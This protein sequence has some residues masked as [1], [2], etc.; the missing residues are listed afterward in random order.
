MA[1]K[2]KQS[3]IKQKYINNLKNYKE[4]YEERKDFL[5]GWALPGPRISKDNNEESN[6]SGESSNVDNGGTN[7]PIITAGDWV[8]EYKRYLS[9]KEALQNAQKVAYHFYGTDWSPEAISALCGNM[10]HESTLNPDMYEYGYTW[11][12]DRGY[13]LVQW[14]PRSKYWNWAEQNGLDPRSGDS[15][16]ARID[17]EVN[18][19]KQWIAKSSYNKMT[20]AQFR[21][22]SGNWDVEYLTEAFT[23]SYERPASGPGNKSMPARK[24]FAKKCLQSLDFSSNGSKK[25]AS[26]KE[27]KTSYTSQNDN[28]KTVESDTITPVVAPLVPVGKINGS[29][30][31]APKYV[32]SVYVY[33]QKQSEQ[34]RKK[35]KYVSLPPHE[36]IHMAGPH[37][38]LY[39]PEAAKLFQILKMKLN[40]NQM[41]IARGYEPDKNNTSSHSIGIAMDIY[42]ET[43]AEAIHVADTAFQI[44]VRSIAI[45]PKFVHIDAGPPASWGYEGIPIYRGPGTVKVSDLQNGFR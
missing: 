3:Y 18:N 44:G 21:Q 36:F 15:Q 30:F 37:E 45:G 42:V 25:S 40:Y 34:F 32:R 41:V 13:G 26:N 31:S 17:W 20:F 9:E 22:N 28:Q 14:T 8:T 7:K 24:A 43:A 23:W 19:N 4:T 38:N 10:K 1:F 6:N 33:E 35:E 29:T 2:E 5:K 11:E 27:E 39:S 12:A 16:L